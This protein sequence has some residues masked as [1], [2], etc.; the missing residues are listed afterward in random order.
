MRHMLQKCGQ[1]FNLR[2]ETDLDSFGQIKRGRR[3]APGREEI[4]AR[5]FAIWPASN[6]R[7]ESDDVEDRGRTKGRR[8]TDVSL[9]MLG[10]LFRIRNSLRKFTRSPKRIFGRH[11][12]GKVS[13]LRHGIP[14]AVKTT[15]DLGNNCPAQ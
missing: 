7:A 11:A 14:L 15:Q 2:R 5:N 3:N 4:S 13:P 6:I 12:C 1:Q 9:V 8:A 10:R